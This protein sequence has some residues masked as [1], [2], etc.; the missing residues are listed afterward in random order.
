MLH[1]TRM[2]A[3]LGICAIALLR[4]SP[5][6]AQCSLE[7][8]YLADCLVSKF[9]GEAVV[10]VREPRFRVYLPNLR[11]RD[12]DVSA[13][14]VVS[15]EVENEGAGHAPAF[16][17]LVYA[18]RSLPSGSQPEDFQTMVQFPPLSSGDR[19]EIAADQLYIP[20]DE[21]NWDVYVI[22][23]VDMMDLR[24]PGGQIWEGN[25]EDNI[26]EYECRILGMPPD[27]S[28]PPPC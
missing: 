18:A 10:V 7:E 24:S 20:D 12:V 27:Y 8:R 23:L 5:A 2:L 28:G 19:V 26:H 4:A 13:N 6:S 14:G 9:T 22:V 21:N 17:V 15:V 1:Q 25:E 11:V 16:E 3:T